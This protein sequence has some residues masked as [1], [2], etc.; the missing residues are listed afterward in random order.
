MDKSADTSHVEVKES[1][2][3]TKRQCDEIIASFSLEEKKHITRRIDYRLVI[4]TGFLFMI[5]PM[6]RTNISE[7]SAPG[8]ES[9][10]QLQVLRTSLEWQ[11]I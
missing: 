6:D 4:P 3:D 9:T 10:K 7:F 2:E 1:Q 11:F 8:G 5:S